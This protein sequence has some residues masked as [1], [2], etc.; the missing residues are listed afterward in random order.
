MAGNKTYIDAVECKVNKRNEIRR[1]AKYFD[2]FVLLNDPKFLA[3]FPEWRAPLAMCTL[4]AKIA[5]ERA[6]AELGHIK[7][8]PYEGSREIRHGV[9][10][11]CKQSTLSAKK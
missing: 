8:R 2:S 11:E 4:C 3:K 5:P 7:L 6:F 9:C 1:G 10:K